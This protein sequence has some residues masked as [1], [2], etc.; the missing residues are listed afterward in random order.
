[1]P[2]TSQ[3]SEQ[4][5]ALMAARY[6]AGQSPTS[7][8]DDFGVHRGTVYDLL[9][10]RGVTMRSRSQAMQRYAARMDAFSQV[11]DEPT[12]YWLGFL[13]A[14]GCLTR[15][16]ST[17]YVVLWLKESDAAHIAA[18]RSFL[19]ANHPIQHDTQRRAVGISIASGQLYDDLSACGCTPRKSLTLRYPRIDP[20][21]ERHFV[22]GYFDG[23]G[24]AFMGGGTPTLSFIGTPTFL[25]GLKEIIDAQTAGNG[26]LYPH[27][28]GKQWY[29]VY[30][31]HFK[32]PAVRDW[33]YADATTW[34]PRKRERLDGFPAGKRKGYP[35]ANAYGASA[36]NVSAVTIERYI[37]EQTTRG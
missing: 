26:R 24:S 7:I 4:Q 9:A 12:A 3:F 37:V 32:V 6:C 31:G 22:R 25:A 10:V 1:M 29:L 35:T 11:A 18:F 33:L 21:H 23:D 5:I 2:R 17:K 19:G 8:G 27:C 13:C 34:L 36:G 16:S 15:N 30:R 14:D 20:L 28:R